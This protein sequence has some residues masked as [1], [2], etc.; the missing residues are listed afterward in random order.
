M[1]MMMMP[2]TEPLRLR[3]ILWQQQQQRS[4]H[5][6]PQGPGRHTYAMSKRVASARIVSREQIKAGKN[7]KQSRLALTATEVKNLVIRVCVCV[8]KVSRVVE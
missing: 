2:A 5:T 7:T 3:E 1:V 8:R 4:P 6:F